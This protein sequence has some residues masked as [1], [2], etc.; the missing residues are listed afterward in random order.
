MSWAKGPSKGFTLWRPLFR[1]NLQWRKWTPILYSRDLANVKHRDCFCSAEADRWF[2]REHDDL[3]KEKIRSHST[4]THTHCWGLG[5]SNHCS[6]YVETRRWWAYGA[7][8]WESQAVHCWVLRTQ[9]QFRRFSNW[10]QL[11]P[12]LHWLDSWNITSLALWQ[13]CRVQVTR[14]MS[15]SLLVALRHCFRKRRSWSCHAQM[16]IPLAAV[17]SSQAC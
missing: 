5:W 17:E 15:A 14:R 6:S 2:S 8:G 13:A 11:G 3:E 7:K 12:R 1:N 4:H 10:K 16:H 9:K